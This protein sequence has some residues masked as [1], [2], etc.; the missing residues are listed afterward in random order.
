V[1]QEPAADQPIWHRKC[2]G[3]ACVEIAVQGEVVMIR[4]SAVPESTLALTRAEW[5]EFLAGAKQGLF[6]SL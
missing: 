5:R 2:D 3:G 1:G 6:D 4:S